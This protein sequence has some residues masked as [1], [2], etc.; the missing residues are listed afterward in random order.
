MF[1]FF[2]SLITTTLLLPSPIEPY[3]INN[4][5]ECILNNYRWE[6]KENVCYPGR[7]WTAMSEEV[8]NKFARPYTKKE[9]KNARKKLKLN[10]LNTK[11]CQQASPKAV[12]VFGA[13]GSGKSSTIKKL[14]D[15]K[16]PLDGI[17]SLNEKE[18]IIFE[19]EN[20]RESNQDYDDYKNQYEVG[21]YQIVEA[22]SPHV[23]KLKIDFWQEIIENK[24]NIIRGTNLEER[25]PYG[26]NY[27]GSLLKN[28]YTIE[29]KF[30]Y[31]DYDELVL[32]RQNRGQRKGRLFPET[33][34][35]HE[36]WVYQIQE[37]VKL[38]DTNENQ[39]QFLS[40][41]TK[42]PFLITKEELLEISGIR[43]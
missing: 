4:F 20:I 24:C 17:E 39:I 21:Y 2:A 15:S 41:S 19:G 25:W 26:S 36:N 16:N 27:I 14:I 42:I 1:P 10:D 22:I 38:F 43:N 37:A 6:Y 11:R 31:V 18:F 30:I 12:L 28:G 40:N 9:I 13:A 5:S 33:P 8:K 7:S 32:R 34:E 23:N 29:Y 3:Q 35:A